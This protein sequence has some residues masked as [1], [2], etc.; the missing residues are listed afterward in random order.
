[1]KILSVSFK[2]GASVLALLLV[3]AQLS[4]A[5][6]ATLSPLSFNAEPNAPASI[7]RSLSDTE[8]EPAEQSV[9]HAGAVVINEIMQNP[10][11]VTDVAGEW[12]ELYNATATTININGWTLR[13]HDADSHRID[14]GG[15]LLIE[16]G[17]YLV[18][19]TNGDSDTNGGVPVDYA[20]GDT[21]FLANGSDEIILLDEAATEIDRVMYDGGS[22]FPDPN[23]SS[24]ALVHTTDDNNAG[25]NW[26]LSVT[27]FG[28]GDRGTPGASN[29]CAGGGDHAPVVEQ[30]GQVE[31][32]SAPAATEFTVAFSENVTVREP[33]LTVV[34][35][36]SGSVTA[37]TGG[38]PQR[39]TVSLGPDLVGDEQCTVTV[40][41]DHVTDQD[42]APNPPV[43]DHSFTLE[44]GS[45]SASCGALATRIHQIQGNGAAFDPL[46]GGI[47]IIEGTVVGDFPGLAGFYVQ[48]EAG[49]DDA[50]PAT[51]EGIFVHLGSNYGISPVTEGHMVRVTGSVLEY[52]TGNGASSRT[53]LG[54]SV[55]IL[56]CGESLATVAPVNFSLPLDATNA[57]ERYE[58]MRVRLS[59]PL[60]IAGYANFT[61]DN[62]IVLALPLGQH[63]RPY[64]STSMVEPGPGAADQALQNSLRR[65]TLDDGRTAQNPDPLRH[66][67]GSAFNLGNRFRGGDTVTDVVG[68]VDETNGQYRIQPTQGATHAAL[69]PRPAA[70]E[71]VE[72]SL[73][74]ATVNLQNY[75]LTLD[76][77]LPLCGPAGNQPCPGADADQSSEFQR[78]RDKL[79]ATLVALDAHV[80]GLIELENSTG[81]EPMQDLVAGLNAKFGDGAYAYIHTGTLGTDVV[82]VG[83]L[84]RPAFVT[85]VGPASVLSTAAFVDPTGIGGMQNRPALAQTFRGTRG[86]VFTTVVTHLKERTSPCGPG[87]DDTQQGNCNAT[88]TLGAAALADWL[89]TDPTG[90][91]DPDFLILGDLHAYDKEAPVDALRT[92][93]DDTA[94][95]TDDYVD[96]VALFQGEP[97]Y[98][99]VD[100]AQFGYPN[101]AM[102]TGSLAAQITGAT[103]WHINA[104]EPDVLDY[105]TSVKQPAQ[106]ALYEPNAFRSSDQDP[107]LVGLNLIPDTALAI[108]NLLTMS[109]VRISY[110]P[111]PAP[112]APAGVYTV[113]S[114]YTNR[115]TSTIRG[116][117]FLVVELSGG[118]LLLN[119]DGGPAGV[120][121]T[122]SIPASA[123][124][125]NGT[126]DPGESVQV[127]FKIGMQSFQ[128]FDFFVD[129]YGI[130]GAAATAQQFSPGSS[131]NLSATTAELA[132]NSTGPVADKRLYLPAI[133]Q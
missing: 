64:Q 90:S 87:N 68:V 104:D 43:A 121:A 10:T 99:F 66:P 126:L 123:L 94:G 115:S 73:R 130:L 7:S 24:M 127:T 60:V 3:A 35:S 37:K 105:D 50:D 109:N 71:A 48:E 81:V 95:T 129:P 70:P 131:F 55:N 4:R 125:S 114:T 29:D 28:A 80:V 2:Y 34:C 112:N 124:G 47:Q 46:F 85:P 1:M 100:N 21:W 18:L 5:N 107:L 59:Q 122:V 40:L 113:A 76:S 20:Y 23:G 49:D 39:Y 15:P 92:G 62:E 111:M 25:N 86:G 57:L 31:G 88:R 26:C 133:S 6:A 42:G 110:N 98:S 30:A 96:L 41:A 118:N 19:G 38:G 75:F 101:Y 52:V 11:A 77:G 12:F 45:A 91:G 36:Q 74:A 44:F 17:G 16:P 103:A 120:G 33:W 13:D 89:A 84:Y 14:N 9:A 22:T 8:D 79:I 116:L 119:A 67:N 32:A 83:L 61:R 102:A 69:N 56:D 97:A 63:E 58:G 72:G 54:G 128:S 51:S 132:A 65:I 78:Q 27:R 117:Y 53:Q 106:D 93:A 82:K 108:N